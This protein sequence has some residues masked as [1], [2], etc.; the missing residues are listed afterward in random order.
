[1]NP[2]WPTPA[3]RFKQLHRGESFSSEPHR[4]NWT[5]KWLVSLWGWV[6]G[7]LV[8]ANHKRK[9]GVWFWSSTG[10]AFAPEGAVGLPSGIPIP[11][12]GERMLVD[13]G[14]SLRVLGWAS[15]VRFGF[16][17]WQRFV[18]TWFMTSGVM[19]SKSRRF[20]SK[21]AAF[22]WLRGVDA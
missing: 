9:H 13:F 1:M 4:S 6:R 21:R 7:P 8:W 19:P 3:I 16:P 15:Y 10:P 14:N 20:W 18:G 2:L 11:Q 22:R 12:D 17:Q 5:L